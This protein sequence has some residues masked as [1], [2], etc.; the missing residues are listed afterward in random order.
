MIIKKTEVDQLLKVLELQ[1]NRLYDSIN[2]F[3]LENPHLLVASYFDEYVA[4]NNSVPC[5][6]KFDWSI[7]GAQYW[8]DFSPENQSFFKKQG[9]QWLWLYVA[10]LY[11]DDGIITP[12]IQFHSFSTWKKAIVK[13]YNYEKSL[14]NLPPE[15]A[16]LK[17]V[18]KPKDEYALIIKAE[19]LLDKLNKIILEPEKKSK[20]IFSPLLWT[21]QAQAQQKILLKDLTEDILTDIFKEKLEL[22]S[23]HWKKLEEIVAELLRF[24]G[25]EIHVVNETPQGGRDIIARG[26]LIPGMDPFTLAI[27]V[28]QK[29]VVGRPEVHTALHQNRYFPSLLFATS[30]RFSAGVIEEQK[31][32]ENK[33]RLIL[34]EGVA[35]KDMIEMYGVKKR[36][37]LT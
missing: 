10:P 13:D 30:G 18:F 5:H 12:E 9:G 2:D 22:R 14:S 1:E 7:S 23:I 8:E 31:S 20:F 33:L 26:E 25:M 32:S 27:E 17:R 11:K 16:L 19:L 28:K 15:E 3:F 35:L 37:H 6:H 36:W 21:P 34:K 4:F 24:Q 29:E